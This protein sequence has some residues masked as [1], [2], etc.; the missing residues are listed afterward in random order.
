M[1]LHDI[2]REIAAQ[3]GR[4]L[5]VGGCVR[6]GLLGLPL[7][8]CGDIDCEVHGLSPEALRALL[9]AFGPV[10]ESGAAFGVYT[11]AQAH[12]DFALP[13]LE[14]RTGA[15]HTD[16]HVTLCP[17][18]SP[19]R[20]AARRDFTVN[21]IMR[22]ALTGE[23]IDPYGGAADLERRVLRAVPG[24]QFEEDPLRVL[25]GA[26]FAARF[27]LTPDADTLAAMARMPL[28]HLSAP[29][30]LAEVKKALLGARD[31]GVFFEV[32]REA[33][34]LEPWFEEV[35]ALC[36]VPQN[37]RYHPEGDAFA[38]TMLV[39]REAAAV[40]D[41]VQDPF[42]FMLAAL[43]HDLGKAVTTQR[44]SKGEWQSIGHETAGV[45]LTKRLL[46]R[47]GV[48]GAAKREAEEL[49][50]L[51]M[52]VHHCYYGRSRVSR[53]NLLFDDC[54]FPRELAL[55]AICDVRG[56][57]KPRELA[58]DEVRFIEE[59]LACYQEAAARPMPT[60]A[61]L[62]EAGVLPGPQMGAA[63]RE[64]RRLV[65]GGKSLQAAVRAVSS[66]QKRSEQP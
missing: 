46:A 52:R 43:T 39:L 58:Q 25:R 65:I 33:G 51:H 28:H 59:R 5:L 19:E 32:L 12:I 3:G 35:A 17:A 18:L 20:A 23:Q 64:A 26:Q 38:H 42:A 27:S 44:G 13:R 41:R 47:L 22:D 7:E 34:A 55:L 4:A 14:T 62:R 29:R 15:L 54:T 10:D 48:G 37:P 30:V 2:A 6:D 9:G 61:M 21:A 8:A 45:P 16:F 50:R 56:T 66:G 49:C 53:T 40:R 63:L 24:G 36:D 31:P 11:L 1:I 60:A 57:G